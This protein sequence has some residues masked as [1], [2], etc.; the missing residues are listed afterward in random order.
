MALRKL[1]YRYQSYGG[2]CCFNFQDVLI[3]AGT[4][5]I[6]QFTKEGISQDGNIYHNYSK[7][8]NLD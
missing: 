4:H 8:A 3:T 7:I 5:L 2:A 6:Y 1:I